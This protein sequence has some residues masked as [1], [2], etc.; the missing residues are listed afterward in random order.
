MRTYKLTLKDKLYLW[1]HENY[2]KRYLYLYPKVEE[3]QYNWFIQNGIRVPIN[4][5]RYVSNYVESL[6]FEFNLRE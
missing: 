4:F 6:I 5:N 2:M 3:H 1:F